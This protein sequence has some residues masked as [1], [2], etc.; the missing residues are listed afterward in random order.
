MCRADLSD[1]ERELIGP[2]LHPAPR[3]RGCEHEEGLSAFQGVRFSAAQQDPQASGQGEASRGS[4]SGNQ[5]ERCVGDGLCARSVGDRPEAAH[6]DSS[7]Y[8]LA[9]LTGNRSPVQ[10]SW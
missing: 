3:W 7:R 9:A 10:L 8:V 5:T 2:L 1:A 6:L 4:H